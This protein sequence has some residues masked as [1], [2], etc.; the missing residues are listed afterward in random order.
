MRRLSR[1]ASGIPYSTQRPARA[2]VGSATLFALPYRL[3]WMGCRDTFAGA[4]DKSVGKVVEKTL[5]QFFPS[6]PDY[7]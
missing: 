6:F 2:A 7:Y 3:Y 4:P 1:D 5:L